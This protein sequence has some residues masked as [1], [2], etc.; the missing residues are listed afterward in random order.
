VAGAV[1]PAGAVSTASASGGLR[2]IFPIPTVPSA[3]LAAFFV[4]RNPAVAGSVDL[5]PQ[6]AASRM[7][8]LQRLVSDFKIQDKGTLQYQQMGEMILKLQEEQAMYLENLRGFGMTDPKFPDIDHSIK[9]LH[10][11]IIAQSEQLLKSFPKVAQVPKWRATNLI[12]R[13]R[14]GEPSAQ[15]EA[16]AFVRGKR[17]GEAVRVTLSGIALDVARKRESS[18]FGSVA[19]ALEL[20]MDNASKAAFLLLSAEKVAASAPSRAKEQYL[21]AAK[22]AQGMRSPSG[23]ANPIALRAAAKSI[24]MALRSRNDTVDRELVSALQSLGMA[25]YALFYVERVALGVVRKQ[26]RQAMT[27]YADTLSIIDLPAQTVLAVEHRQLDIAIGAADGDGI[28]QQWERIS[29][30]ADGMTFPGT[31]KRAIASQNV[32]W[33]AVDKS[34]SSATVDRFIQLH[35]K[36]QPVVPG[37]GRLDVWSVRAVDALFKI[38]RYPACAE[39]ADALAK[40]AGNPVTKVSAL[41]FAARSREQLLGIGLEPDF[42]RSKKLSGTAEIAEAYTATLDALVPLVKGVEAEMSAFQAAYVRFV[43]GNPSSGRSGFEAALAKYPRGKFSGK[44]VSFLLEHSMASRDHVYTERIA[45]LAESK[46]IK[47]AKDVHD[48]LRGIIENAVYEQA[49]VLTSQ[50]QFEQGAQKYIAFQ[51]EFPKSNRADKALD[52]AA[53]NYLQAKKVDLAIGQMEALLKIYP[54]SPLARENRWEAAERSNEIGQFLR[55]ANHYEAFATG[56]EKEGDSRRA[57]QKAA[58][59]H[60]KIGRHANAIADLE[61]YLAR[62]ASKDEKVKTAKEIADMHAKY[63]KTAD[64]LGGYERVIQLAKNVNDEIWSRSQMLEIHIRQSNT[65]QI[66][67]TVARILDLKPTSQ[68]GFRVMGKAKFHMGRLDAGELREQNPMNDGQLYKSLQSLLNKYEKT[69]SL[70]IAPCEVPGLEWCSVG[71]YEVS[72]LA[73][74]LAKIVFDIETPPTLDPKEADKVEKLKLSGGEKLSGDSKNYANL[75]ED[76]ISGGTPD[77]DWAERIRN[78]AQTQRGEAAPVIKGK[79]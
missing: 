5:S 24:E 72:H 68:D 36:L 23:K 31:E 66:R 76:A 32:T 71:Y 54:T 12:S 6:A 38:R 21:E 25:E 45:R 43:S 44:S 33:S 69:K 51:K 77:E 2:A 47:P 73:E 20:P 15:T 29:K 17:T 48:D 57:W 56:Y 62:A 16:L 70:L 64:A 35:D 27:F 14:I 19:G 42:V 49:A 75:A 26:P 74:E 78:W 22:L 50:K 13:L 55:A 61:K 39:R 18:L 10:S 30:M 7:T 65:A 52:F 60:K 4:G 63:G 67:A 1:P 37:Y 8:E 28:E 53:K 46:K 59:M 41:R 58:E 34:P 3:L 9:A 40:S 79:P 11:A